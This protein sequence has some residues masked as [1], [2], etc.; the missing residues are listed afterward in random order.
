MRD[1]RITRSDDVAVCHYFGHVNSAR[2]S[3]EHADYWVRVTAGC[4]K[5]NG[6]WMVIHE[7]VS[8]PFAN[9]ES[10]QAVAQRPR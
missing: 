10:M 3:G 5:T 8:M 2:T 4:R 6:Q 9:R 7:H 1:L